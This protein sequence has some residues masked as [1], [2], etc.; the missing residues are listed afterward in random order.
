[1]ISDAFDQVEH[2]M[3]FASAVHFAAA[4]CEAMPSFDRPFIELAGGCVPRGQETPKVTRN[5]ESLDPY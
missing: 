4:R 5:P 1:L 3:D 2:G